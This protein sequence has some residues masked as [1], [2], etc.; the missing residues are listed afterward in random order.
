VKFTKRTIA[1]AIV[2][3]VLAGGAAYAF[4]SVT[5]VGSASA[6]AHDVLDLTVT[7][8]TIDPM[9]PGAS[10]KVDIVV[11]NPNTFPVTL[12]GVARSGAPVIPSGGTCQLGK[13]NGTLSTANAQVALNQTLA[14]GGSVTVTVPATDNAIGLDSTA[15]AA[16]AVGF[17]VKVTA[18]Q[19]N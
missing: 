4:I 1:G 15:T 10:S 17:P 16:C 19:G 6:S 3:A 9:L 8:V 11:A 14:A 12:T 2:G 13:L 18:L 7:S 5:G